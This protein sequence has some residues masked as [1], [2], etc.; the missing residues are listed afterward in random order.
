LAAMVKI[1][2]FVPWFLAAW[3]WASL[4]WAAFSHPAE[5]PG[6]SW[7]QRRKPAL[8]RL[9]G[10]LLLV[11]VPWLAVTW[12]TYFAD[13]VKAQNPLTERLTSKALAS[14]NFGT[15]PQRLSAESWS[16]ILT[17]WNNIIPHWSLLLACALGV[18]LA[19]RYR[20]AYL[21]CVALALSA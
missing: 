18:C 21:A 9:G 4:R 19:M 14:W 12:W 3:L 20:L 1:T 6:L 13:H 17:F 11:T 8:L 7:K 10:S 5:G 16:A 15:L 2:S